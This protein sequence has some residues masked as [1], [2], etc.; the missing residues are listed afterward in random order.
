VIHDCQI[1]L[2]HLAMKECQTASIFFGK[3]EHQVTSNYLAM[4]LMFAHLA[5]K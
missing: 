1:A 3:R 5:M 4:L 2:A